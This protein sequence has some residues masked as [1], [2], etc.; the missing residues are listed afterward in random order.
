MNNFNPAFPTSGESLNSG[1]SKREVLAGMAMQALIPV[2]LSSGYN[3]E[4]ITS[5]AIEYADLLL[6]FLEQQEVEKSRFSQDSLIE[7]LNVSVRTFQR[8]HAA[9]GFQ[10]KKW[11]SV[12]E[13]AIFFDL[14]NRLEDKQRFDAA[15]AAIIQEIEKDY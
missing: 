6:E 15:V 5:A 2:G 11:Y 1:L 7:S 3:S 13:K 9:L 12:H 14:K 8:W 4:K 10:V